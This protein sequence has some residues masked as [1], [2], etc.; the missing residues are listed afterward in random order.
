MDRGSTNQPK[1][2]VSTVSHI[3]KQGGH[4]SHSLTNIWIHSVFE[5]KDHTPL[6]KIEFAKRLHAHIK[7]SL[8]KD[9]DC[10]VKAISGINNHLHLL[11]LLNPNYS[12]KDIMKN[13]KG[14]SSHW[15]NQNNFLNT[16]FAWQVGYGAFSV[17]NSGVRS[18]ELYIIN[19]TEHLNN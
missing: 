7:S 8:E 14:E 2:T 19:Q 12:I 18:V 5:T 17:S 6:I 16:K 3:I 10:P 13:I 4:M 11:F 15:I 9:F 1:E